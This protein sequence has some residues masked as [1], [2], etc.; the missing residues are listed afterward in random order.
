MAHSS[1]ADRQTD[2]RNLRRA[3]KL[4]DAA[5]WAVGDDGV[6]RNAQ[7]ETLKIEF[8]SDDPVM[9][10]IVMPFVDNLRVMGID[11][12]YNR[13][14]NA[15]FTLRRR[16]RDFDMISSGYR[17]SLQP[18]TGLYQQYGSEA[19]AY[20]VFNPAGT[21]RP[22]YRGADRQYRR[23]PRMGG[24]QR[25]YPGAGPGAAGQAVHGADLVPG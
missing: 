14:D 3:M 15:Q 18:S 21:P 11:A 19:A 16:E 1:R 2:R 25:Q 23:C 22:G 24:T 4:L 5:G 20:S 10:R 17:T 8:L 13:I 6:R 12:S 9:D 7:G